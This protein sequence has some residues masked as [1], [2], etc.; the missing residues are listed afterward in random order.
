MIKAYVARGCVRT[1]PQ[2]F[3]FIDLT[4]GVNHPKHCSA[5]PLDGLGTIRAL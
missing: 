3:R 4:N 1:L 2:G 5:A